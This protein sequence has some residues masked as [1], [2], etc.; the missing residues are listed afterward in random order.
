MKPYGIGCSMLKLGSILLVRFITTLVCV[1]VTPHN[2]P[3][4]IIRALIG[5]VLCERPYLRIK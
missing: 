3:G 2:P 4:G 5:G 1:V